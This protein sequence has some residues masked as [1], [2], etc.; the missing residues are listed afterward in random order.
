M[1]TKPAVYDIIVVGAGHAGIEAA[2]A[3]ARLGCETLLL[4]INLDTIGAMPCSPS[5]G[6]LGKGHI[7]KELDIFGCMMPRIADKTA[8]Q[9]RVLNTSKGAAVQ[10]TRTQND[11]WRY[12][13][14]MKHALE[15][16]T[17]LTLAQTLVEDLIVEDS[18]V[19]GVKDFIGYEYHAKA[20]IL[21]NGTFLNG[22]IH[23][24]DKSFSGGRAGEI[25]SEKLA[26][27]LKELGFT[28][29]R[30]KTGTPP[31]LKRS[32]I[33]FSALKAQ[34]GDEKPRFF[35]LDTTQIFC[36]QLPCH[37]TATNERT[38]A[39]VRENLHLSPLYSGNIKGIPARYCPSIEDKIAKFPH[40]DKHQI[41]LEPE[42]L[43]TEEVY[44]SGLGNSMPLELQHE[45]VHSVQGLEKAEIMRPSYAIEY[46]FI[47]PTQLR[48]TLET[49]KIHGLYLAGQ[50]NGTSGYEEAAGQGA[51]AGINAAC[52]I[53]GRPP[54]ILDRSEGYCGV[55]IDD[56][57]TRGTLEPY[58]MFTSRAE[59]RLLLR[60]DNACYRLKKR[61]FE[62]GLL[63]K[64]T[65]ERLTHEEEII[66]A[67][68][69]K[70]GK[71]YLKP[72]PKTDEYLMHLHADPPQEPVSLAQLLKRP[73]IDYSHIEELCKM[74]HG[75]GNVLNKE[76]LPGMKRQIA[77][78]IKYEGYIKK[79][80]QEIKRFK[81]LENIKLP[82]DLEYNTIPGLS[83][84]VREKLQKIAP[85][86][87]GQA[88]RI[89]GITSAALSVLMVYLK[90]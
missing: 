74:Y 39:I 7:V 6:G 35:S 58:R 33:D 4:T 25:S 19:R 31:R 36:T 69:E 24:G 45:I 87:L 11:K 54:F 26:E 84:E 81:A 5:I 53:Q 32:T 47:F 43:G 72:D 10:G 2:V 61:A 56:L 86:S 80:L 40:H 64:D 65:F 77:I 23:I 73:G 21:T 42:G 82:P 14:H 85:A 34:Y 60:E 13:L 18:H 37:M 79:Q 75:M 51:L 9:F 1:L 50:I 22:L 62:L 78:R 8:L 67:E 70:L 3:S 89:E 55:M 46:N 49:K 41:I 63:E 71:L 59:Y 30:L 68:I 90:K 44:A 28:M 76:L 29:G 20:V 38:H 15:R 12:H 88:S 57:V 27:S 66:E 16:E 17:H 48:A 83:Y 52:K